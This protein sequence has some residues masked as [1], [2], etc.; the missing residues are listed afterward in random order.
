MIS[1]MKPFARRFL[2]YIL[3]LLF[4]LLF[5]YPVFLCGRVLAPLDILECLFRPW[6]GEGTGFGVHNGFVTD[7]ISQYLPYDWSV[8]QS[9]R[10]DGFVGWNPN[11]YGGYSILEN[12]MLCPGDWHHQLYRIL[13]FWTAWNCGILLQFALAGIGTILLLRSEG[14]SPWASLLGAMAF[15]F[16]SQHITW[17]YHRW[18][19]GASCWFPW[20]V[21]SMRRR[22]KNPWYLVP[23][24]LFTTLAFRGGH[25]QACLFTTLII[26]G[27]FLSEWV[28]LPNRWLIRPT[29]RCI[30]PYLVLACAT[31][32][33]TADVFHNTIPPY[34]SGCREL[35]KPTPWD[36]LK[37]IITLLTA[38]FPT[39]MGTPQ[40]LDITKFFSGDLFGIKF[41]GAMATILALTAFPQKEAPLLPKVYIG[42]ALLV[43]FTPLCH[44]FYARSSVVLGLGIAWLAAWTLQHPPSSRFS[45]NLLRCIV[46][47]YVLWLVTSILVVLLE[48]RLTPLLHK[49]ISSNLRTDRADR[50]PWMLA[51]ADHFLKT[52]RL[53]H[54]QQLVPMLALLA[55][56]YAFF[57]FTRNREI[58]WAL[59]VLCLCSFTEL[60]SYSRTWITFSPKPNSDFLYPKQTW[61]E[62]LQKD[63]DG[64]GYLWVDTCGNVD[65]CQ[66]NT[67][68]T[69][70][71][72]QFWGYETIRPHHLTLS[73]GKSPAGASPEECASVGI[74]HWLC[75][76]IPDAK[77]PAG[78]SL[79]M[80]DGVVRIY[81][82]PAFTSLY[83]ATLKSGKTIPLVPVR[84]SA[85]QL[86]LL[87]PA[88]T[89]SVEI[90]RS[91][92]RKWRY[93]FQDENEWKPTMETPCHAIS[94]PCACDEDSMLTVAF[95]AE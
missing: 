88:G 15:A 1:T 90:L 64:K 20:I 45:R 93:H 83:H 73:S 12:T 67:I 16:Y 53:W 51:R 34:L 66:L 31:T 39:L 43:A 57:R 50:L 44:W 91:F 75:P 38:F 82:N 17:I 69:Y 19:L 87:L 33:L 6:S 46:G 2:P 47:I 89:R 58:R 85:N 42:L 36:C 56:A 3:F 13:P 14:Q 21:W 78:W 94:I 80:D 4:L 72:P 49:A 95:N 11:I 55:S 70:G 29:F 32:L 10:E 62:A 7:A 59:P 48:P 22:L 18:V 92:H 68:S 37:S 77:A 54:P 41:A 71:I 35:A 65:F 8:Y 24:V 84:R 81:R 27:L 60:F 61:I 52:I 86:I 23:A 74:S 63:M 9:L 76:S 79:V 26:L 30:A 28:L 40:S 25:L 5:F